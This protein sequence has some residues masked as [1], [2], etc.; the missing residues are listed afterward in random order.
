MRWVTYDA[1]DGERAGLVDGDTV[2]GLAA[3]TTLLGLLGDD[4]ERLAE[5]GATAQSDPA[6]M[7]L[8]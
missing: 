8:M 4:G 5:A 2:R 1:G 6:A 7:S 3:G